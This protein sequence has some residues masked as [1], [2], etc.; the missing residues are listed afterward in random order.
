MPLAVFSKEVF[1]IMVYSECN[2]GDAISVNPLGYS[3]VTYPHMEWSI[4]PE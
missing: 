3:I 1:R 2:Y 4:I